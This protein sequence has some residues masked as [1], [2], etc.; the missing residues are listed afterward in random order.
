MWQNLLTKEPLQQTK[1][2]P[3][4]QPNKKD[5]NPTA[6]YAHLQSECISSVGPKPNQQQKAQCCVTHQA[7]GPRAGLYRD[8][9]GCYVHSEI[10]LLFRMSSLWSARPPSVTDLGKFTGFVT[11]TGHGRGNAYLFNTFI[12]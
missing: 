9:A 4:S 6:I 7:D 10:F 8:V 11:V 3:K 12:Y 2:K 5:N 1:T